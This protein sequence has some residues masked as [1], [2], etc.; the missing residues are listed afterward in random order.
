MKKI[1]ISLFAL[2]SVASFAMEKDFNVYTKLGVDVYSNYTKVADEDD[3]T[4][5][6][7]KKGKTGFSL[8]LEATKN[9]TP[10]FEL[11]L[12]VGH[13]SRRNSSHSFSGVDEDDGTKLTA[14]Y[15]V[16]RYKSIPLYATAKY[17]FD[18]GSELKPYVKADLGYSFNKTNKS[19]LYANVVTEN[20][21]SGRVKLGDVKV[22]NG[23]YAAIGA[24]VEYRNFLTELSYN[25]TKT[26]L[27]G[28]DSAGDTDST[29]Y[30][31][32][33]IKLSVGY[34]FNF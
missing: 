19:S 9:V 13:I 10:N 27:K 21:D 15:K 16:P 18:L 17:N 28:T 31:N 3:G 29:K 34:K 32:K 20:G 24:G 12:G 7:P 33:A 22:K 30:N 23:L 25:F 11:G 2:S 8:F 4:T 1:L 6:F 26:K 14:S 5:I